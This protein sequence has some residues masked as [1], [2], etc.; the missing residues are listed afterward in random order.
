VK[1]GKRGGD[2]TPDIPDK[3][4]RPSKTGLEVTRDEAKERLKQLVDA[5]T[6]KKADDE[7][8]SYIFGFKS[9]LYTHDLDD[10][11]CFPA[12]AFKLKKRPEQKEFT[13][14]VTIHT[15]CFWP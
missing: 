1:Q 4:K 10:L 12:A 2:S 13:Q 8:A 15:R 6:N 11:L 9:Y 5:T 14:D 3:R 7:Q